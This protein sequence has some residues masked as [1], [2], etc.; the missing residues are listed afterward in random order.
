MVYFGYMISLF[1][2]IYAPSYIMSYNAMSVR[3]YVNPTCCTY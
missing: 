2:M 3:E 1:S